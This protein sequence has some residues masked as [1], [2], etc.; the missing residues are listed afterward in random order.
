MSPVINIPATLEI[1]FLGNDNAGLIPAEFA[2]YQNYP[3]PFNP[4]TTIR[5][6]IPVETYHNTSLR[7]Y[8]ITG[9]VVETLVNEKLEPGQHEIQWNAS[10]HSSGVYFLRM[11]AV[12][13]IKTQKMILLK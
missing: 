12:S 10:Q 11:N 9:R 13:F 4:V 1:E 3:N 5:F 2:L 6:D 7:I 8:D